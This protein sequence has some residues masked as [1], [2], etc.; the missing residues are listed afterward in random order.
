MTICASCGYDQATHA[1]SRCPV[2]ACGEVP[3]RHDRV[4][5][6]LLCL[7]CCEVPAF[8]HAPTTDACWLCNAGLPHPCVYA[9]WLA[10]P[11]PGRR[12]EG[13]TTKGRWLELRQ[14]TFK[15]QYATP[16]ETALWREVLSRD[17]AA[18]HAAAE[19]KRRPY[20]PEPVLLP[21]VP[22]RPPSFSR[23][24]A[25]GGGRQAKGLGKKA[26]AAGW[27]VEVRYW[28]AGDGTEGC[29]LRMKRGDLRGVATWTRSAGA[30]GWKADVVYAWRIGSGRIPQ[31]VTLKQLEGWL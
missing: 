28:M 26:I 19:E 27:S 6:Q 21:R 18:R 13:E 8:M 14:G 20:A 3:E 11:C 5:E 15:P 23:E 30:D 17:T 22:A 24:F 2:C 25:A 16:R 10:A 29:A 1:G 31:K 4:G 9:R 7:C 12:S